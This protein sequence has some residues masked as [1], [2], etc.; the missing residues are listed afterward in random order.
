MTLDCHTM[1]Q[2]AR[3]SSDDEPEC[4]IVPKCWQ[5]GSIAGYRTGI[6]CRAYWKRTATNSCSQIQIWCALQSRLFITSEPTPHRS[7]LSYWGTPHRTPSLL[8]SPQLTICG[9]LQ[10]AKPPSRPAFYRQGDLSEPWL[11]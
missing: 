11:T 9:L 4:K 10:L 3:E 1:F 8:A 6:H 7:P 5:Q 2:G